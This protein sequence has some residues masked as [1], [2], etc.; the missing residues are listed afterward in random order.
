MSSFCECLHTQARQSANSTG[1]CL[2]SLSSGL[3][4]TLNWKILLW[5]GSHIACKLIIC[6]AFATILNLKDARLATISRFGWLATL[7]LWQFGVAMGC[8][9]YFS[10][11]V[12]GRMSIAVLVLAWAGK[13]RSRLDFRLIWQGEITSFLFSKKMAQLGWKRASTPTVPII[14]VRIICQKLW[15]KP[16]VTLW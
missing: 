7:I 12:A 14:L 9:S 4:P 16:N 13:R 2:L 11:C 10:A 8:G 5:T 15:C 3:T 6:W 1:Y